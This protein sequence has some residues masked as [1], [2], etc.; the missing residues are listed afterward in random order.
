MRNTSSDNRNRNIKIK[1]IGVS[2]VYSTPEGEELRALDNISFDVFDQEFIAVI[3]P[4][5]CGKTTL[6]QIIAGLIPPSAGKIIV[7]GKEI[8]GPSKERGVIFQ[9]DAIFPWRTVIENVKFG[10][11]ISGMERDKQTEIAIEQLEL[12]G[13][14]KFAN[15]FPKELSGGMKKRVAIAMVYANDPKILLM[16]EPFGAL[17]YPTKISLQ[18]QL[19]EMW[20][21]RKKTT[22]FITHDIEEA[23]FLAD[24]ILILV[25]GQIEGVR[26]VPFERP[27]TDRIRMS[28]LFQEMKEQLWKYMT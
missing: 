15:F 13:L 20:Q 14:K 28:S 19:L 16:D 25:K 21:K 4:S 23:I 24:R 7:E 5:G 8:R 10:L 11:E 9:Q 17:D 6:L 22:L 2:K 1:L 18:K 12:V 3:G 26:E 27:R